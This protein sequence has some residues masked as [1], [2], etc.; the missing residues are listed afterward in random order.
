MNWY[1][2]LA[3][4]V[5]SALRLET[6]AG[7]ALA[8]ILAL[9]VCIE[10]VE[11]FTPTEYIFSYLY[12]IPILIASNYLTKKQTKWMI[13]VGIFLTL[14]GL[15]IPTVYLGN[16]IIINRLIICSALLSEGV[17]SLR[18]KELQ[19]QAN[20]QKIRLKSQAE[21]LRTHENFTAALTHDLK[22]PLIGMEQTLDFLIQGRFDTLTT[23]QNEVVQLFQVSLKKLIQLTN[24]LLTIYKNEG[25]KLSLN[26]EK[27]DFDMLLA[28][29]VTQWID[30]ARYRHVELEYD[31]IEEAMLLAD[32][33]QLSRVINNLLAN[34]I[35]YTHTGSTIHIQ[36]Q[37]YSKEY[38]V[39]VSDSGPGI[40]EED[41][42]RIFERFYQ[43]SVARQG[44]GTG[45]GL[46]VCRQIV[47]A[48]GGKI[49]VFNKP[50]GG[51][52]FVFTIPMRP[53]RDL[54]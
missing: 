34:A 20:E 41:I 22:T 29:L 54:L 9:V 31:G 35:N 32:S 51:C 50:Q 53:P 8:I 17:L 18:Y 37:R 40:A 5:R 42:H 44:L 6:S 36:L 48:H 12:T 19:Q 25:G 47:E 38:Q 43:S 26:Y 13:T 46:Y 14:L 2:R 4:Y 1:S 10:G 30:A 45:L 11:Y 33:L 21:L 39:H 28:D 52:T 24:T 49:W 7:R 27:I 15:F 16:S 3:H 23:A